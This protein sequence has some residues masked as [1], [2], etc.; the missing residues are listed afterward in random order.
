MPGVFNFKVNDSKETEVHKNIDQEINN[1]AKE[2]AN[3]QLSQFSNIYI[4][5]IKKEI[6]IDEF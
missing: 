5:K 4:S 6:K 1:I 2:I 3:K